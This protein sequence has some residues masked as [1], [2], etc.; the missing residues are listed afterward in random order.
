VCRFFKIIFPFWTLK[1]VQG[2]FMMEYD[3][4][5]IIRFLSND[6]IAAD[7]ITGRLQ[8]QFVEHAYKLRIVR[9][10][11]GEVRF[12]RQDLHN[13]I[14]TGRPPLDNVD[15][16]NLAIL[17]KSPFESAR[18]IAER[19]RVSRTTMLN[20]LHMSIGFKSFHLH[21]VQHLLTDD[22][23]QKRNDDAQAMLPLL[24][25]T[26]LDGCRT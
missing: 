25:A 14:R 7:E 5:V 16:K 6:G 10:W 23:R 8:A 26:E 1:Y 13:K 21:C 22:L 12:G 4:R 11:I 15:A 24:L 19:L 9:F 17:D 3:Q 18:S 20:H 2:P